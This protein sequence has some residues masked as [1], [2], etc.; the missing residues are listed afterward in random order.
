MASIMVVEDDEVLRGTLVD[1]L[2]EEG[3]GVR[4]VGDAGSLRQVMTDEQV[5]LVLLDLGLP[6]EDGL[7]LT[8]EMRRKY[9][10][11]AIV[12]LTGRDRL[13]DRVS[14]LRLGADAYVVKPFQFG[15][16]AAIVDS[17]L[18]RV[19]PPAMVESQPAA[20]S[21]EARWRLNRLTWELYP[22]GATKGIKVSAGEYHFLKALADAP[23]HKIS[24]IQLVEAVSANPKTYD[25]RNLDAL[26]RRLRRKIEAAVGQSLPIRA[27]H[28]LGYA[29]TDSLDVG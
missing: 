11:L 8:I 14:G 13:A 2:T 1:Y 5:D 27:I 12:M 15:E 22:P 10:G 3:H 16:L 6:D 17:V 18:R 20:E 29:F 28:A 25:P 7:V 4:G 24:R 26:L 23:G 9:P 21:G 19:R